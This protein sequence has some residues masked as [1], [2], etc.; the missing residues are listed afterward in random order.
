MRKLTLLF[1]LL[2]IASLSFS[3]TIRKEKIIT[4]YE[5]QIEKPMKLPASGLKADGDVFYLEEFDWANPDDVKGWT[6]PE[7][8][9]QVDATGEDGTGLGLE[10]K[11]RA[12]SDSIKGNYT[13][14]IGHI[15]SKSP[16][17][18]Y[19]VCPMDEY[20]YVD[21]VATGIGAVNNYIEL[22]LIDCSS[23]PSVI[24]GLT[25]NFRSCCGANEMNLSVSSDDGV[26]WADWN[27]KMG[28]PT[29]VFCYNPFPEFNISEV[30]AGAES[31]LIRISWTG[32]THYFWCIDDISLSE[33]YHNELRIED[34]W[35]Y[36]NNNDPDLDEGF[37][38]MIPLTQMGNNNLL[39][40]T[41]KGAFLN[42]GV[43][44]QTGVHL[45]VEVLKNGTSIYNENSA[46][47][48]MTTQRDTFEIET[49]FLADDYGDYQITLSAAQNEEDQ[50]PENNSSS[51]LV[52]VNDSVYARDDWSWEDHTGTIDVS[53][54]D[55]D[56]LGMA[57][58]IDQPVEA[59]SISVNIMKRIKNPVACTQ[60]GFQY[61]FAIWYIDEDDDL[62]YELIGTEM[63]DVTEETLDGRW[64]T[65]A[66]D[67]DG[68]AEFLEAGVYYACIEMW[69]GG[70]DGFN[71]NEYRF[72]VGRDM[73]NYCPSS[74]GI[75]ISDWETVS[76]L[77]ALALVRLNLNNT[78]GPTVAPVSFNCDMNVQIALGSFNPSSDFVDVAGSFN[79][80]SGSEQLADADGD[81]VYS[82]TVPDLTYS[83]NIEYK[84][85]INGSDASAETDSRTK[86]VSYWNVF[87][88]LYNDDAIVGIT[89][90][91]GLSNDVSV[92]PNPATNSL[93]ISVNN[94]INE[95][96]N[97]VLTNIQGQVVYNNLVKS[98][99]SHH[100]II[101]LS[102]FS[103]GIYFLRVN[104]NVNKI[105][106]R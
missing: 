100:E 75:A 91:P 102:E 69:T 68:E 3:Q 39:S 4:P 32:S 86:R 90:K 84:Y 85:R 48:D 97:I 106:V 98:V 93:N 92:Y 10:W 18:G 60:V 96:L 76:D 25:Q 55:G 101:D 1:V 61:R 8:W 43:D 88:D 79:D 59:N 19:L 42:M 40:Y 13:F 53:N 52:T 105:I 21:G 46:L 23:K 24:F 54:S 77:G 5:N 103:K 6:M 74:R 33:A 14:E 2:F 72:S 78:G 12:G 37:L 65:L 20:Q 38:S 16:E 50:L 58:L 47:V 45:N 70:G 64:T 99:I 87:D 71:N 35:S 41:F 28:T 34:Q 44:D 49:P 9:V 51:M 7:G 29:N 95:D 56:I 36:A 63:M 83:D 80:W 89:E 11:W 62:P 17:N 57:Y 94:K 26:H 73:D 27:L 15:Y 82:I 31:V 104:K 81:G 66:L 67:K 30:A 22:P